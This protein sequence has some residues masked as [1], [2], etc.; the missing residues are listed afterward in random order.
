M[1]TPV[2]IADAHARIAPHIRRTPTLELEAGPLCA[3]PVTLKLELFQHAGSFKARG[4][5]NAILSEL[6]PEAG[7]VA[8]SGGNHGAAVAFA[9]R[10]AGVPAT[11]FAP[12]YAS[13]T[14]IDRMRAFGAEVVLGG[15]DFIA[16][17]E[18]FSDFAARTGARPIHPF[19]DPRV[20]AGQGTLGREI[21]TQA[22]DLDTL[23]VSVGGGGL[24]GGIASWFE[25]R[26]EIVAVETEGT[27]TLATA[28]AEGPEARI[29]AR[30]VAAD[31]LGA[32]ASARWPMRRSRSFPRPRWWCRTPTSSR[33]SAGSGRWRASSPNPER[34]PPSRR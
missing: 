14:K 32:R 20:L 4:A 23:L 27:A 5:F 10:A 25:G 3:A 12:D 26:I 34:P 31:S 8:V 17:T 21:E 18:A 2:E 1:P 22:P 13:P 28:L 29:A 33:R 19:D 24:I 11:V 16:L 30:G 9:A 6:V 15:D 7:V